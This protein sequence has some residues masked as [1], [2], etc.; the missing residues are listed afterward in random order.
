MEKLLLVDGSNLLF[1]MYYGMPARIIN[2]QGKAIQGTLGFVG[3]LLKIIRMIQ[4]SHVAVVF[5]GECANPRK[6]LDADYKANR[7]DYSEIED[8]PFSQLPDI[9]AALEHLGICHRETEDCEADDWIAGYAARYGKTMEV[10]ISSQD[11]DFFQLIGDRVRIL[12][13]RGKQ[14]VLCDRAYLRQKLNIQP[15]QYADF[16]AMTGDTADNIRGADQIGPKTAAAL[17]ARFGTLEGILQNVESIKKPSVR[18]SIQSGQARLRLNQLLIRLAGTEDLPFSLEQLAFQD[19]G[20]T[21]TQIL[22]NI[23]LKKLPG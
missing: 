7:P 2:H 20:L 16:K 12:R 13:Y 9:Y 14:S 3:A 19:A 21:T 6:V 11:S 4:P 15:E 23:G 8:T 1:Q 18:A 17:L 10:V 5:D 22:Q